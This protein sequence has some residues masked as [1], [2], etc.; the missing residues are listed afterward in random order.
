MFV[1]R[2]GPRTSRAFSVLVSLLFLSGPLSLAAVSDA[3]STRIKD[4]AQIKGVR[5]NALLGYG[6]VVGLSKTGDRRQTIFSFQSLASMLERMGVRVE[7]R[8]IKVENVAAVMV[9]AELPPFAQPGTSIDVTVASIGDAKS[10]QGGLLIMTPLRGPDEQVYAIAQG[11]LSLAGFGAGGGETRVE[12]NHLTVGRIPNGARI[13]RAAP[14]VPLQDVLQ[15]VLDQNDFTTASNTA[16]AVNAAVGDDTAAAVDGRTVAVAIPVEYRGREVEF[17]ARIETLLVSTDVVARVVINERTGTI[18]MGENVRVS[19]VA[20]AH[21]GL[22][23]RVETRYG[24]SQPGPL[25]SAGGETVVVP[26][27]NVQATEE[28]ARLMSLQEGTTI[29]ELVSGL[30]AI[31]ASPRDIVA[32]LQALRAAGALQAEL[33]II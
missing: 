2:Y 17:V 14:S 6:I 30:N 22:S 21:G 20:V 4:I 32:I 33:Q 29:A 16:A 7:A 9:T 31:G 19:S 1:H 15:I 11:P 28:V 27:Q 5:G 8:S 23:V 25:S 3:A 12:V 26:E 24:V 18:V 10:L 13:E